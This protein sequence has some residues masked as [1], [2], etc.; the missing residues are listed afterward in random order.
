MFPIGD[1]NSDRRITPLVNYALIAANILVF[2]YQLADESFTYGYSVVP[3]EITRGVDLVG[4]AVYDRS[5]RMIAPPQAPG[6]TPIYLTFLSAMFMHGGLMHI[7]GNMLYLWI[8]GDNVEDRMGHAKYLMFYVL[9]GILAS[10]AHIAF[11]PQSR[12]PSLGASGAIAGVLGAYLILYPHQ[13]VR[14]LIPL[15]FLSRITEMPAIIV[16]GLWAALQLFS[17][18]GSIAQTA[19]SG[20]VA[21]M[22]HVGGFVAGVILV[23]LFRNPPPDSRYRDRH[24][25]QDYSRFR[26]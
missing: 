3:Y 23:F 21:Y 6:P 25:D 14:V 20:G 4:A 12:I 16:I 18:I 22:A 24:Y 11:G 7:G 17:G 2:L 15:G 8:F 5:G 13:R 9:C 26:K 10:G 19:E 1:D